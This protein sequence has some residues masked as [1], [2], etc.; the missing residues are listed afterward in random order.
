MKLMSD[1]SKFE[2]RIGKL[3]Y[4]AEEIYYF[5][6]DIRNLKRFIPKDSISDL[7][8]SYDS[9]SFRVSMLGD[10]NIHISEKVLNNKVVFSGNALRINDFSLILD[11]K[12]T[13]NRQSEFKVTLLAEMNPLLKMVAAEP[14]KQFLETLV[15]EM[16]KFRD[17]KN[18]T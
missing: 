9:C 5:V 3:N 6:T 1:S 16:E 17:W 10:V 8:V 14:V 15:G 12:D 7:V 4:S 2:S 11:L 18:T 13:G